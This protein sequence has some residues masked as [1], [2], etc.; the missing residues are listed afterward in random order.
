MLRVFLK[1]N[2]KSWDEFL[3][4]IEFAYNKVVHKTINI[5]SFEAVYGFN[6]LTPMDLIPLPNV[7][8]FIHKEGASRADF[9]RKLHERI[10]THIQLQNE[11]Y[12]KSNNKGKR[13]LIFEECDWVWLHI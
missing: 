7:Q 10:K 9:V 4:H 3:P 5:S 12:A 8:H 13:K 6:P 2:K 11:K 1:G